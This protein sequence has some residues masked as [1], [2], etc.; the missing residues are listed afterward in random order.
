MR[1]TGASHRVTFSQ[2]ISIP[3]LNVLS[4]IPPLEEKD[5]KQLLDKMSYC[6]IIEEV[7]DVIPCSTLNAR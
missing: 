1:F 4:L 3:L 6:N 2:S 7:G 5:V